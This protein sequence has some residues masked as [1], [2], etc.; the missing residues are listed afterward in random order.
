MM[1]QVFPTP[2]SPMSNNLKRKSYFFAITS[3]SDVRSNEIY[4]ETKFRLKCSSLKLTSGL[5]VNKASLW[6]C[7]FRSAVLLQILSYTAKAVPLRNLSKKD[8]QPEKYYFKAGRNPGSLSSPHFRVK[9]NGD[10]K[11]PRQ[12]K[13]CSLW[14]AFKRLSMHDLFAKNFSCPKFL[15]AT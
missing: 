5:V 11:Y 6:L 3:T 15:R 4:D 10:D 7:L 12:N 1:R 9:M 8:N 14:S 2:L 13:R